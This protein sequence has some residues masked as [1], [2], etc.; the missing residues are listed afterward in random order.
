MNLI[1]AVPTSSIWSLVRGFEEELGRFQWWRKATS[2]SD[3]RGRCSWWP[4][5]NRVVRQGDMEVLFQISKSR[6]W[7]EEIL[8]KH[9][10]LVSIRS[11]VH[12]AKH[13][14]INSL[15]VD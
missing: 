9:N 7:K 2:S 15:V 14:S 12:M 5:L 6:K 3:G 1:L 4:L 13:S 10:F 8:L 11:N